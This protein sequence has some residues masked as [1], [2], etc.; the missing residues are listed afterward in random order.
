MR[1]SD[2]QKAGKIISSMTVPS[3]APS[4]WQDF[5]RTKINAI[6]FGDEDI[7]CDG[8]KFEVQVCKLV[9]M[10]GSAETTKDGLTGLTTM[11]R[12]IARTLSM[13]P[14]ALSAELMANTTSSAWSK[15]AW[16]APVRAPC[17]AGDTARAR[18]TR[19]VLLKLRGIRV[20]S[21]AA[22]SPNQS[23]A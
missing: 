3:L 15:T 20:V 11:N 19:R 18:S 21:Q 6:A 4:V 23:V 22:T 17:L 2:V 8:A 10:F 9:V 14:S 5:S 16:A 1:E 12:Q 7:W 13:H